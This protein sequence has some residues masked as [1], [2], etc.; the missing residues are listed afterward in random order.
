MNKNGTLLNAEFEE[1]LPQSGRGLTLP[2]NSLL[3]TGEYQQTWERALEKQSLQMSNGKKFQDLQNSRWAR[4]TINA[5]F[6]SDE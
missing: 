3:K 6:Q 4:D 1:R 2:P 5:L